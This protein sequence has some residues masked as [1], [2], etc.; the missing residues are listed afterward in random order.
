MTDFLSSETP[1]D[2]MRQLRPL[3]LAVVD[4]SLQAV[5]SRRLEQILDSNATARAFYRRYLELHA[6][7]LFENQ[8]AAATAEPLQSAKE[9]LEHVRRA[10]RPETWQNECVAEMTPQ[11]NQP[12]VPEIDATYPGLDPGLPLKFDRA[13]LHS[14]DRGSTIFGDQAGGGMALASIFSPW[15]MFA[16][17]VV[18]VLVAVSAFV[19]PSLLFGPADTPAWGAV[20]LAYGR[21]NSVRLESGVTTLALDKVGTVTVEGPADFELVGPLRARLNQGRITVHVTEETGHGFLIETP[22]GEVTDFGTKFTLN[23]SQGSDSSL[24][25]REGAVDLRTKN[26]P[27]QSGSDRLERLVGGEAVSF[28]AAGNI[29]RIVSI[30]APQAKIDSL[31]EPPASR[32]PAPLIARV[33][34]NLRDP[35]AKSYYEIVPNGLREDVLAYVDRPHQWNGIDEKG[36]P[37]FLAGADYIKTFNNDKRRGAFEITVELSRPAD[38]YVF[39]SDR[40]KPTWLKKDFTDTGMKI[41]LD[42]APYKNPNDPRRIQ[43]PTFSAEI[44]AGKSVDFQYSI[45]RRTVLTP[46]EIKLGPAQTGRASR[47]AMYGIAVV[48]RRANGDQ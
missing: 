6:M 20:Q 24:I 17:A 13:E 9:F 33:T 22:D 5:D 16:L 41:G 36:I 44:G 10:S 27:E 34:D 25:V 40:Q 4:G 3:L 46:G 23:V 19:L 15:P 45:W 12:I 48:A 39:W 47:G 30:V 37:E 28:N 32:S 42:E 1:S 2:D 29:Q 43:N 21:V 7:L 31:Q 8:P 26:H 35:E 18:V 14:T 38:V 11:G